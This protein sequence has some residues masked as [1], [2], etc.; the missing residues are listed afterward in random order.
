M[1]DETLKKATLLKRELDDVITYQRKIKNHRNYNKFCVYLGQYDSIFI[2][3]SAAKS[4]Y[5]VIKT[6]L[7]LEKERLTSEFNN[8]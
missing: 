2:Y 1:T 6:E 5:E 7:E 8:L 4:L 3:G